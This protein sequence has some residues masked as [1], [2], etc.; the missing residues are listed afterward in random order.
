L[1]ESADSPVAFF[2]PFLQKAR[3]I[4]RATAAAVWLRSGRGAFERA[5]DLDWQAALTSDVAQAA[6]SLLLD[7]AAAFGRTVWQSLP[8]DLD[9]ASAGQ[10][11]PD[12]RLGA[13]AYLFAPILIQ[14]KLAG[15]LEIVLPAPADRDL[16][17]VLTRLAT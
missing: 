11:Q 8:S 4:T 6:H 5:F 17:R 3:S 10:S 1:L 2:E 13:T 14:K 12:I 16:K 9:G 7:E 15:L